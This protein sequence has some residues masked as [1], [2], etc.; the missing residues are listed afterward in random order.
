[1]VGRTLQ[2]RMPEIRMDYLT[3]GME[4]TAKLRGKSVEDIYGQVYNDA[5]T[6]TFTVLKGT[7]PGQLFPPSDY[8]VI[9]TNVV[10]MEFGEDGPPTVE[11]YTPPSQS[12]DVVVVEEFKVMIKFNEPI[13]VNETDEG[14][15]L[16]V[17]VYNA[18]DGSHVDYGQID[19][20]KITSNTL[21]KSVT[22]EL[23]MLQRGVMY[24]VIAGPGILNDYH[25]DF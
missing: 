9:R 10:Q 2:C 1:M 18:T 24:S 12:T 4:Y 5:I 25:G 6:W 3:P 8:E 20:S 13:Y 15:L 23:P 7:V 17:V 19:L 11:S 21:I 16:R 14:G 22:L